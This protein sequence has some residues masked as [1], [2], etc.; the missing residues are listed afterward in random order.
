MSSK[1]AQESSR[2]AQEGSKRAQ[3]SSKSNH[4]GAVA[5]QEGSAG[6]HFVPFRVIWVPPL[7]ILKTFKPDVFIVFSG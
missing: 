2:R 3:K 7:E 5:F 6:T 1:G 4:G